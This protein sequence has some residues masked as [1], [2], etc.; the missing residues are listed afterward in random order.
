MIK[1]I[2]RQFLLKLAFFSLIKQSAWVANV[3]LFARHPMQCPGQFGAKC[4]LS[5]SGGRN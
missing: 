5:P 1:V 3:T 2:G 4:L